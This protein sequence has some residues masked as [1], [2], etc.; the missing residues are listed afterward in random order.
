MPIL[1]KDI[2]D[3]LVE[4]EL[5]PSTWPWQYVTIWAVLRL[6]Q[7]GGT[8]SSGLLNNWR[9]LLWIRVQQYTTL[10]IQT[11]LLAHVH[12]LSL[13]YTIPIHFLKYYCRFWNLPIC[14]S[15]S[16]HIRVPRFSFGMTI[17]ISMI[18]L[19]QKFFCSNCWS[20]DK[21]PK[22]SNI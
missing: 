18:L 14:W 16:L 3:A 13:R 22:T 8:G 2:V 9:S 4:T 15:S 5:R 21:S 12:N 17:V 20:A 6:L 11:N 7:G 19:G 1:Y 10:E